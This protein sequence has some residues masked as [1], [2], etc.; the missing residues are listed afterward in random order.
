M[1]LPLRTWCSRSVHAAPAPSML[2]LL[3]KSFSSESSLGLDMDSASRSLSLFRC[4]L[5]FKAS[6]FCRLH[7]GAGIPP[8]A[9]AGASWSLPSV[10]LLEQTQDMDIWTS[11]I[12]IEA[13]QGLITCRPNQSYFEDVRLIAPNCT[14]YL[15]RI[16]AFPSSV[17]IHI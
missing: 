10:L 5:I 7:P 1:M 14:I 12:Q 17:S 6:S 8:K 2:L 16:I 15:N 9:T 11:F 13:F 4:P 3:R